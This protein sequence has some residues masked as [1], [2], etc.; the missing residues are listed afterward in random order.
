MAPIQI[1]NGNFLKILE[2]SH[3]K[4]LF[5]IIDSNREYLKKWLPWVDGSQTVT[6]TEKFI[7]SM[8]EQ[9]SN[10]KGFS[11]G[12]WSGENLV[13]VIGFHAINWDH[14]HVSIGYW[15]S[16][17]NQG[18]GLMTSATKA[19]VDYAIHNFGL[20]RVEIRCATNNVKSRAIPE[21]LGFQLEGVLRQVERLA[22]G[23]EDHAV[24]GML[25]SDW[26]QR[27]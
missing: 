15:I 10:N 20:N 21:R 25:A 12:I 14:G 9:H 11:A 26:N 8:R 16:E 4:A 22:N 3:A 17:N 18:R 13:G 19:M 6:D 1:G 27:N 7:E 2:K 24:Y 5:E 23:T